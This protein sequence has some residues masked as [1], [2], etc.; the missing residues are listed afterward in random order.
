MSAARVSS[1]RAEALRLTA[2]SLC[3]VVGQLDQSAAGGVRHG[4]HDDEVA[5]PLQQILRE[6]TRVLAGVDDLVD[7]AEHRGPVAGCHRVDRLVEQAVRR[8]AE[9]GDGELVG[10]AVVARAA[11]QLVE[12]R[13]AV[14]D[15][16]GAGAD[17]QRHRGLL[18]RDALRE[19]S[20]TT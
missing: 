6:A 8:V 1:A 12:H 18:D 3:L 5:E 9:Q 4:A 7:H 10:H 19:H 11:D 14:A 2:E 17:H 15:G 16:A 20:S 13:Q